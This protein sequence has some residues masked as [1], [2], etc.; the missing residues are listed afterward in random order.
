EIIMN[1][2]ENPTY[3]YQVGGSLRGDAPSYVV[4]KADLELE[5]ALK[6]GE[7]CY[8]LNPRQSGKS[9]LKI[10]T[11]NK[12]EA[13]GFACAA[14]DLSGMGG[15]GI[16]IDAWYAGLVYEL[17]SNFQLEENFNLDAWWFQYS[18]LSPVER[19]RV[20][21]EEVLLARVGENIVIFFDEIDSI[22]GLN[23]PPDDFLNWV[24]DCYKKRSYKPEY[25]RLNLV[26]LGVTT[27]QALI[28]LINNSNQKLFNWG[29]PIELSGFQLNE[30]PSLAPGLIN[31]A[32]N[33]EAVLKSVLSWTGGQPF[34]TQK[35]CQIIA[36][37]PVFLT[38]G[39]ETM[40]VQKLVRECLVNN[41]ELQDEPEHLKTIRNRL[42]F[43]NNSSS[44]LL[45]IYKSILQKG[46]KL[47]KNSPAELELRLSGIVKKT[48]DRLQVY[49]SIYKLIFNLDWLDSVL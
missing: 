40:E 39:S 8:V 29:R 24:S 26:L 43:G 37:S 18:L 41:W 4:R 30:V 10:R 13:E 16:T 21:I 47:A 42:L 22:L 7:F 38:D 28:S 2:I 1:A 20:F 23:F 27:P 3:E 33:P 19:L 36:R 49:N 9:S 11:K 14:I 31:K 46:D 6:N 44:K 15:S 17:E 12:L 32:S 48:G 34:L 5:M 45:K 35:L 25:Q